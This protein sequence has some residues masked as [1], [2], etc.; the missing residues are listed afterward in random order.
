MLSKNYLLNK[1]YL[2][3]NKWKNN[4]YTNIKNISF[5]KNFSLLIKTKEKIYLKNINYFSIFN[6]YFHNFSFLLH[7]QTTESI[8]NDG[9]VQ[10]KLADIGEGIAEC[11]ILKWKVKEGDEIHQF[12]P[13]CEVQ[14]DKATVEITSRYD[15]IVTKLHYKKGEMAKVGTPLIDIKTKNNVS[16][17]SKSSPKKNDIQTNITDHI[18]IRKQDN[19]I[20]ATPAVRHLAAKHKIP[21]LQVQ[22]TGRDGRILK[23]DILNFIN[24]ELK[25]NLET[26][27]ELKVQEKKEIPT[28][29]SVSI[30]EEDKIVPLSGY[31][32]I[33]AKTMTAASSVPH[34][35]YCDEIIVDKLIEL[36]N[37]LKILAQNKGIKITYMPLIIKATSLALKQFPILNSHF[38]S[39]QNV[40]I[41]KASHNIGVAMD[42]PQ[43]LIVPNIKNVQNKTILEIAKE[44][45]RLHKLAL[46]SGLPKEDLTGGTFS[47]SNIG[48]IGGTYASPVLLLPEVAIGAIGKIMKLPRFDHHGNIKAINIFNVSWSADHRVIDGA[49]MANF[50]NLWKNYL[51]NPQTMLLDSK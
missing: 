24:Q 50:S 51:E 49:T 19:Q 26:E 14:S 11:E 2:L 8:G 7:S 39:S 32:R 18:E 33:M 12:D 40:L 27:K 21:L 13:I 9:I 29:I 5:L 4:I 30:P 38:D 3:K 44:L 43:G 10:F 42:T 17:N 45:N 41:Y 1:N 34:F 35:G 20:L 23:E 16:N 48:S 31:Q 37:E 6:K 36:R 28:P 46:L 22:G 47:L 15:G 25:K